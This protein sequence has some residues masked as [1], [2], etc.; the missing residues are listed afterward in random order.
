MYYALTMIL[1]GAMPAMPLPGLWL[2]AVNVAVLAGT[3][4]LACWLPAHRATR[5]S[6]VEA[7][8]AE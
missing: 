5:I 2:L 4:L 6:P 1:R 3:M 8:R 7:L